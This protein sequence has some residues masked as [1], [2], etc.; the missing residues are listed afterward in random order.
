M[1][2]LTF[3][4]SH[5]KLIVRQPNL[6][7]LSDLIIEN[8][9]RLVCL[10][11]SDN[12]LQDLAVDSTLVYPALEHLNGSCN[13][14][15]DMSHLRCFVS[16]VHVDLSHNQIRIV[17]GL[18][19]LQHLKV[20]DLSHN[21]V[22]TF[23]DVRSMSLNRSLQSLHLHHNPI[24]DLKGYR[25]RLA[26]LLPSLL[27]LDDVRYPRKPNATSIDAA[28]STPCSVCRPRSVQRIPRKGAASRDHQAL[29][30]AMRSKP[31]AHA[32]HPTTTSRSRARGS[33]TDSSPVHLLVE[34]HKAIAPPPRHATT[35][36]S[37][38]SLIQRATKDA[39]RAIP[40]PEDNVSAASRKLILQDQAPTTCPPALT[41]PVP[42]LTAPVPALTAPVQALIAPVQAAPVQKCVPSSVRDRPLGPLEQLL[43]PTRSLNH[44]DI[45]ALVAVAANDEP[46]EPTVL[47]EV[48]LGF[49]ATLATLPTVCDCNGFERRNVDD[50]RAEINELL[51][52]DRRTSAHRAAYH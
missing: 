49:E 21:A 35:S 47:E 43:D 31:R 33:A 15:S 45:M 12:I 22:R 25:A 28:T 38:L 18:E 9:S 51:T 17:D 37:S 3:E 44:D 5:P 27:L 16:L 26:S 50:P 10:N 13:W 24:A 14:I 29:S 7:G 41:A 48:L 8:A 20:L 39:I 19:S 32:S 4:P 46:Y 52:R 2:A 42:A 23:L 36:K 11:V 1:A 6:R 40:T 34:L 30:D